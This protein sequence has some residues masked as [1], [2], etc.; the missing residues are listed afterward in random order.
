MGMSGIVM[1][2]IGVWFWVGGALVALGPV[3]L[4]V[5][6]HWRVAVGV[7]GWG[8]FGGRDG[9]VGSGSGFV[10]RAEVCG[11][12]LSMSVGEACGGL[13]NLTQEVGEGFVALG[14]A[15]DARLSVSL[16]A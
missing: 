2:G 4:L 14:R 3:G 8:G 12:Q 7:G 15:G 9:G 11:R 16:R 1:G 10:G 13:A 5:R 6:G